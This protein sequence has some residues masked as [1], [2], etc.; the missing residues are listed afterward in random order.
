MSKIILALDGLEFDPALKLARQVSG[1][2]WAVK[3]TE[4][5]DMHGAKVCSGL[6]DL[7]VERVWVD[8]KLHDTVHTVGRRAW[9]LA[10]AGADIISCHAS[11][12]GHMMRAAVDSGALVFAVTYLTSLAP[13]FIEAVYGHSPIR[14]V[15]DL[16]LLA[17]QSK[18]HG[19]VCAAGEAALLAAQEALTGLEL[20]VPGITLRGSTERVPYSGQARTAEVCDALIAGATK[21]VVGRLVT[22]AVEP[23]G[24]FAEVEKVIANTC[25]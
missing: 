13:E 25:S 14:G 9:A 20:V 15:T 23:L 16:A 1:R 11:G 10:R 18:V 24:M 12:G 19:V 8:C 4:L 21:L 5:F 17:G 3:V 2:V 7:G 6:H 22:T